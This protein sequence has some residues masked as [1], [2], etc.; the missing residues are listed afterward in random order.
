MEV[1][2]NQADSVFDDL[3]FELSE[4]LMDVGIE[5]EDEEILREVAEKLCGLVGDRKDN[6]DTQADP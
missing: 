2:L 4:S 6:T 3:L 5:E 1:G